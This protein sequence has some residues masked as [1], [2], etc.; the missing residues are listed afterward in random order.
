MIY[1][2]ADFHLGAPY[3]DN[4]R[5]HELRVVRWLDTIASDATDIFLLGDIFDYWYEYHTVVPK[6]FTRFL[7][8]IAQ[9]T[10]AGVNVHFFTG[11]HDVWMFD[12]LPQ[13]LGVAVHDQELA[14]QLNN[15]RFVIG[16]GD[17][18]G[19]DRPYHWLKC[20]FHNPI[21]QWLYTWV[22]PD[23]TVRFAHWWSRR[24]RM[25]H[26]TAETSGKWMDRPTDEEWQVRYARQR[27]AKEP[28]AD[29]YIFGHRHKII[30]ADA[31]N[32][33]RIIVLGDWLRQPSYAAFDGN[34][35]SLLRFNG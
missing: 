30:D 3:V 6:G 2:A 16:H 28:K 17:D 29:F 35:L 15:T 10:D 22:H 32:G 14:L 19:F 24:S 18:I 31:G 9:L 11:N 27:Q 8:K 26:Y 13:E 5:E 4:A 1:F 23:I 34:N 25:G 33:A 20:F 21:A 12:Y 7:G